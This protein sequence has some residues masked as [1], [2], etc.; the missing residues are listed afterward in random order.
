MEI[1]LNTFL[2]WVENPEDFFFAALERILYNHG[3]SLVRRSSEIFKA[4]P[5]FFSKKSRRKKKL[6]V[7][8]HKDL[9]RVEKKAHAA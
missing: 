1:K 3:N 5:F 7:V 4:A 8:E 2:N 6:G 9:L